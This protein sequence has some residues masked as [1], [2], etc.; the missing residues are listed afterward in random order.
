MKFSVLQLTQQILS[1]LNS[2][3]VNSIGD[4][5]ES[6]QVAT[7]LQQVYYNITSRSDLPEQY[8]LFQLVPSTDPTIPVILQKPSNVSKV[9]WIKYF[10]TNPA[11][12]GTLQTDQFG[13]YSNQHD[14]NTDLSFNGSAAFSGP[15]SLTSTSTITLSNTNPQTISFAGVTAGVNIGLGQTCNIYQGNNTT[16]LA[17]S[18]IVTA[19]YSTSGPIVQT[20]LVVDVTATNPL[21]TGTAYSS[22][23]IIQSDAIGQAPGY[24]YV[25]ILPVAPFIDMVNKFNGDMSDVYSYEFAGNTVTGEPN[26]MFTFL[27][28]NDHQPSYCTCIENQYF[29]FDT[30]D[31]TQDATLQASKT[32]CY[33]EMIPQFLLQD[34]FIPQIDDYNFQLLIAE[35]KELAFLELKQMDHPKAAQE[36]K[37]QWSR[38]QKDKSVTNKPT[39]FNQLPN[40][41]RRPN[42]GGYG[43]WGYDSPGQGPGDTWNRYL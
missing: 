39:Y 3:Q 19:Y 23:S 27:Y 15:W 17:G 40:F 13:S 26:E 10:D 35:A 20:Y 24:C 32:M 5:A 41:G 16:N 1:A 22:W 8:G 29:L 37:R 4:T 33:G 7:I 34:S 2:D 43:A 30:F 25:R 28:K 31:S 11:D 38:L 12:G 36:T 6:Y 42:T 21:Y 14:T 9:H 18:G